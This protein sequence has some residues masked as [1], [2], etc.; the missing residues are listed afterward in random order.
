LDDWIYWHFIHSHSSGLQAIIALSLF[1][2]LYIS[3]LHKLYGSQVFTSHLLATDF[4][5]SL[6]LQ[7]KHEV[8]FAPPY[9]FLAISSRSP[10]TAISRTRLLFC[11]PSRLKSKSKSH[12]DWRSVSKS[13]CRA[14]CGA[15]DQ[16]FITVWQFR[17]CFCGAPSL[18]RGRVCLLFMLLALANAVFLG[19]ESLGT[20]RHI[21][22]SQI[23]DFP[24]RRLLRL[25]GSRRRYSTPSPHGYF[26]VFWLPFYKPLA[27]TTQK[28][29]C[30][31]K[32]AGLLVRCLA[33]GIDVT[34]F[35]ICIILAAVVQKVGRHI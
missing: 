25:A 34:V 29:A 33:V 30:I 21:V 32:E 24:F 17:S 2:T 4:S 18:T 23:W 35:T 16:I 26:C 12:Y 1:Y 11:T 3:L 10:S 15:H 22:L 31:V 7:I 13:W 20:R 8:F 9:S 5:V 19:S 14:P 6:S 27:R 28:T